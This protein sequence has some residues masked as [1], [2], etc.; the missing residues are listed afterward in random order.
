VVDGLR[1]EALGLSRVEGEPH[2]RRAYRPQLKPGE[3]RRQEVQA[4]AAGERGV[5]RA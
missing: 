5:R 3:R 1:A 4:D 2:I